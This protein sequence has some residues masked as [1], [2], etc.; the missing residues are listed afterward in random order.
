MSQKNKPHFSI[1]EI[2]FNTVHHAPNG[3]NVKTIAGDSGMSYNYFTRCVSTTD[4][5][6]Q[7]PIS[8]AVPLMKSA[9]DFTLLEHL[10]IQCNFLLVRMPKG[11]KKGTDPMMPINAYASQGSELVS[12]LYNFI[13]EPSENLRCAIDQLIRKHMGDTE[14]LRRRVKNHNTHQTELF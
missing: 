4:E 12:M 3:K 6:C 1:E 13:N 14:N 2:V 9:D 7:L 5:A 11:L 8:K 10:A